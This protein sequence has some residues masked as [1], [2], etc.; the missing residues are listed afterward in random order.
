MYDS[1]EDTK[2]HIQQVRLFLDTLERAIFFRGVQHDRTKL[3][4]PE[5]SIFD[6]YTPKLAASTYGSDEYKNYLQEMKVALNHHYANNRHHPE[7]HKDGIRG[8]NLV[9][10]CEMIC[11]WKAATMRHDNGDIME[12]IELNQ[13][14]FGYSDELKQIL[15]N[16][17]RLFN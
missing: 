10:L 4:E 14:R 15:I 8:M 2:K 9:D 16:T 1:S 7:F 12:S 13:A 5:K 6:E 11:D 3:Q 17:V